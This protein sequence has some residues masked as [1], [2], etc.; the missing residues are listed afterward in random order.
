[1][2]AQFHKKFFNVKKQ[3]TMVELVRLEQRINED[4]SDYVIWFRISAQKWWS[5]LKKRI[6]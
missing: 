2:K 4:L 1:M 6:W 5:Q 3:V